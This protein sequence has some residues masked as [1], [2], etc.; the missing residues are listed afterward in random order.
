MKYFYLIA[1]IVGTVVPY[2]FFTPFI[3]E[4]GLNLGLFIQNLFAN[5]PAGGFTADILISSAVFWGVMFS[6]D[7]LP[8]PLKL[9]CL[10]LNLTIGLSAALPFY[11]YLLETRKLRMEEEAGY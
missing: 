1:T 8:L 3:A 10:A 5:G 9:I 6:S 11:A 7:K 2:I 4:H